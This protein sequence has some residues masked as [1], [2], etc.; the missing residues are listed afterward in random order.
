MYS[1][2][3]PLVF[4]TRDRDHSNRPQDRDGLAA[5]EGCCADRPPYVWLLPTNAKARYSPQLLL[6]IGSP[7]QHP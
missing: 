7:P 5:Q 6:N 3:T 4:E 1:N 2:P